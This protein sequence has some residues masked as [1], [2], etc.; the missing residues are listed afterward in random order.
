MITMTLFNNKTHAK[1][2]VSFEGLQFGALRPTDID[3]F[4]DFGNK[5]FVIFELKYGDA[6]LPYGQDL[7][8]R[9]LC[10]AVLRKPDTISERPPIECWALVASHNTPME[11]DINAGEAIVT[12]WRT[13]TSSGEQWHQMDY[14][15]TLFRFIEQLK[16][17]CD[18]GR[19][20]QFISQLQGKT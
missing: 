7:A 9:R 5:L 11:F 8:I 12:Q 16:A 3:G 14:K 10:D 1:Q 4:L 19:I 2:L 15:I 20:P 17:A 18:A 6:K 13:T